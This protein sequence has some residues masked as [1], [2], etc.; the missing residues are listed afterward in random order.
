MAASGWE[1]VGVLGPKTYA[2]IPEV[3]VSAQMNPEIVYVI[4]VNGRRSSGNGLGMDLTAKKNECK[5]KK[6]FI[7]VVCSRSYSSRR[8]LLY[9]SVTFLIIRSRK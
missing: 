7:L 5:E 6:F 2:F 4:A 1:E 8:R 9:I 3:V